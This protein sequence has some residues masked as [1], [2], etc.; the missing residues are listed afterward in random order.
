MRSLGLPL[1][2]FRTPKSGAAVVSH[3]FGSFQSLADS[4]QKKIDFWRIDVFKPPPTG[5]IR[6]MGWSESGGE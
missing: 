1:H 6:L 5:T 2:S 4:L 3:I